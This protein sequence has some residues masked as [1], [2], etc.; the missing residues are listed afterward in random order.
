MIEHQPL[1]DD[2]FDGDIEPPCVGHV[3]IIEKGRTARGGS[4]TGGMAQQG[5][6]YSPASQA[7]EGVIDRLKERIV[8]AVDE[9]GK[10]KEPFFV[11]ESGIVT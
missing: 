9:P 6:I 11:A 2:A 8:K 7:L 10:V 4:R 3:A 1:A 5:E